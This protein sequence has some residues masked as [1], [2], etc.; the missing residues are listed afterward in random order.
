MAAQAFR[1]RALV[2][3]LVLAAPAAGAFDATL[4]DLGTLG[5][6]NAY[7][8]AISAGGKVAGCAETSGGEIHAFVWEGGAMTSLGR[9][10]QVA[11]N[12]CAL[13]INDAGLVAGRASSGELVLWQDGAVRTLGFRGDIGDMNSSGVVVGTRND[14]AVPRAFVYSGGGLTELGEPGARSEAA[15]INASGQVVGSSNGRAFLYD[16]GALRDL[17]TLGG[18]MSV[19]RAINSGGAVVG[20]SSNEF[21]QPTPFVYRGAMQALP[22]PA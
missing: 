13:A 8:S 16:A 3:A 6:A 22:G 14:G 7:A 9:G 11:G 10:A 20:Q 1:L 2:A 15:A 12:A 21:G 5:G 18:A 17:G 19:A 4:V